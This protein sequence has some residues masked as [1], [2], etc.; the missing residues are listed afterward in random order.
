ML[1]IHSLQNH[2]AIFTR[3]LLKDTLLKAVADILGTNDILLHH[4]KAHVKPPNNGSAFPM[5]QVCIFFV[6]CKIFK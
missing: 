2:A 5:H 4:T 1:S 6:F 3:M